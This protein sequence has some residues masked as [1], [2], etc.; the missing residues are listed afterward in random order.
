[1]RFAPALLALAFAASPVLAVAD[2]HD[3]PPAQVSKTFE[4]MKGL[5]GSWEGKTT[6][7]GKEMTATVSYALTSGGTALIET[8][9]AGTPHEMITVYANR[10]DKVFATHFCALGNQPE[11]K[12]KK[13]TDNEFDFAMDGVHGISS[14]NEMHMHGVKLTLNGNKLRQDWVNFDKGKVGER[15][16]F[17][18]A[19]KN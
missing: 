11:F 12:L 18:F 1:M 5:V 7:Q 19:R 6:M 15:A 14:K 17:E 13:A 10:G 3:H 4:A 9:G 16:I 2:S 8:L